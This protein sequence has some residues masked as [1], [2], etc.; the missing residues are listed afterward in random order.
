ARQTG[1]TSL[2]YLLM[3]HLLDSNISLSQIIYLDL[4]NIHDFNLLQNLKNFDDFLQILREK[5]ADQSKRIYVFIDEIQHLDKPSSFLKYL[6][7]HYKPHL[8]FIV[9]GSSSLEIKKKFT[10]RLTGRIYRF[11]VKPLSFVEFL[12]FKGAGELARRLSGFKLEHLISGEI[13]EKDITEITSDEKKELADSLNEYLIYGGYPAVSLKDNL[14]VKQKDLS[15]IYSLYVRWDI[16]DIGEVDDIQ[17]YNR[18][19]SL[20]AFQIGS[21]VKEL[22]LAFSSQLS[23]PTVKKYLFLL[24]NTFVIRLVLPFFTN[25]RIEV[26]KTPK[27]YFEDVGLRNAV[28]NN[29]LPLNQR[30]DGGHLLE[31]FVLSELSKKEDIYDRIRYWR[32]QSKNEVDFV[33]QDDWGK[34]C[35]IEVKSG[36]TRKQSLPS[37]LKAF[38]KK[39]NPSKAFIIMNREF[40]TLMYEKTKIILLPAWLI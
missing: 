10:D 14:L 11:M 30:T 1:K 37:G 27:V 23:R 34:P 5:G 25:K 9:T 38:I 6:H 39:Y 7:D 31:N 29:F 3:K 12:E 4:E 8:K 19:V 2:L 35:P 20:L 13:S 16:K 22:E 28:I 33:W 32:T 36:Y 40:D 26:T 18:V 15:E 17:G 21:L 24:E